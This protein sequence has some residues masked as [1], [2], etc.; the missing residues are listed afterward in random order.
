M[1]E[2]EGA[3]PMVVANPV[4]P[5]IAAAQRRSEM[6]GLRAELTPVLP[7]S[8][9]D[10]GA[11]RRAASS[12]LGRL[13]EDFA[14]VPLVLA[15]ADTEAKLLDVRFTQAEVGSALERASIVPGVRLAE[16]EVG[17][18]A[19]GTVL[20][21][22]SPVLVEGP[23]HFLDVFE[24]F[25]CLGHPVVHPI[26]RRLSGVV[27]VGG[28]FG[29]DSRI[30][31]PLAR[32]AVADIQEQL[33]AGASERQRR[34]LAAYRA[35]PRRAGRLTIAFGDDVVLADPGAFDLFDP[36]GHAALRAAVDDATALRPIAHRIVLESGRTIGFSCARIPDG[37]GVLVELDPVAGERE[38][39]VERPEA[40]PLLV[41]GEAG[42]GRT[43]TAAEVAGPDGVVVDI[44]DAARVG[45]RTVVEN[46]A[47]LL[48]ED[49]PAV[50]IDDVHLLGEQAAARL[51]PLVARSRRRVVLTALVAADGEPP[52]GISGVCGARKELPPL[53]R[54]RHEI[55]AMAQR[56]LSARPGGDRL[57]LRAD[58]LHVLAGQRWPGNLAELGRVIDAVART[59]SAGDI[60]AADL[61]L[62]HRSAGSVLPP[63]LDAERDVIMRAI[64]AAGGNKLQ[65]AKDLGVSRSTLYNRIRALKIV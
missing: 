10:D 18:N 9:V 13:A 43:R 54:R 62:S 25:S 29:T 21:A 16:D 34:L 23:E 52:P 57:R 39:G 49:G 5:E 31:G 28:G 3:M 32:R 24:G 41:L 47:R 55:P 4:K 20:E 22:R 27:N 46:L 44:A 11:L 17:T 7:L 2:A 19:I 33:V 38:S 56:M 64:S 60:T 58:A 6:Y 14:E 51:V 12:V 45:E 15:A 30:F 48:D 65:A 37:D 53:R 50:V 61:P 40:W 63:I 1:D 42:A 26:T 35:A 8:D 36:V 59:R